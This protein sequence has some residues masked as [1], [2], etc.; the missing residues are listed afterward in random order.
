MTFRTFALR[1][2]FALVIGVLLTVLWFFRTTF[3]L[4]FLAIVIAVLVSIPVSYLERFLPRALAVSVSVLGTAVVALG[5]GI[6]LLPSI[7]LDLYELA[8]RLP[9]FSVQL[10]EVYDRLSARRDLVGQ[11]LPSRT[12]ELD[13]TA[14]DPERLR[15]ILGDA[16]GA[17]LP[18]LVSGGNFVFTLLANLFL[19]VL[20]AIF[21]VAEPKA[22]VRASLYLV[23]APRQAQL[24]GLWSVLYHTLRTWLSTVLISVS[25]TGALV[26]LVLGMLG[27]PNVL[28]V[29]AF[30]GL[31]TVIPNIGAVLPI[32]PIV[33]FLLV[34][35]PSRIPLM[36]GAYLAIQ[37][38][39]SNLLTP[40]IVR[41]QLSIPPAA[42]LLTQILAASV[43]GVLGILLAVPLL[44]LG[45]TLVR[46][47]YS[48]GLL[49][50]RGHTVSVALPDPTYHARD[51]RLSGRAQALRQRYANRRIRVVA[52]GDGQAG[53]DESAND[54]SKQAET[55]KND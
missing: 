4:M 55:P 19:V 27:M 40:S 35:D 6:W 46:E 15:Q 7:G 32:V 39:E 52:L 41:R 10:T 21:F 3:M 26:W 36:V 12:L 37:L 28:V 45:I 13:S 44:A 24:L 43:F 11:V 49:G 31:A 23:P 2:T 1:A 16:L 5:L 42:T 14:F 54:G 51:T 50:L 48:Y 38:L 22:Y 25:L 18:V 47:L 8:L 17:G 20:L 33:V 53:T 29:A 30:A 9:E 34:D